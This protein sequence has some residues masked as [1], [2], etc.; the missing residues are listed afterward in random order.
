[1]TTTDSSAARIVAERMALAASAFLE[2]LAQTSDAR[3]TTPSL[4]MMS[5][6]AGSTRRRTMGD[7]RSG[8]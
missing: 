1:M 4:R 2:A 5:A 3:P 8:R 6:S 7:C